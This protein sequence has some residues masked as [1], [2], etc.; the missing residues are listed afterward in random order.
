MSFKSTNNRA[1]LDTVVASFQTI[2]CF[3]TNKNASDVEREKKHDAYSHAQ[4]NTC[5]INSK[6]RL[7][8][9][10]RQENHQHIQ[11]LKPENL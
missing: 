11:Q 1:Y 10:H 4:Q 8:K 7:N 2:I 3:A 9:I 6:P 5:E